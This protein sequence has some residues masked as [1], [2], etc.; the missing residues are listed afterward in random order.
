MRKISTR[1]D[2]IKKQ[3]RNTLII[4]IILIVVI[5]ASVFGIVA[6]SFGESEESKEVFYRGYTFFP[7]GSFWALNQGDFQFIFSNNP[8]ELDNLTFES[9]DLNLLPAY[10]QKVLYL[11]SEDPGS[12]YQIYQNLDRFTVRFQQACL[13][14]DQEKCLEEVPFKNCTDN[15]II[16]RKSNSSKILQQD[17]CV[18][19]EGK[20][21]DLIKLTDVF[22]LKILGI[23]D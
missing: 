17:N 8:E 3:K 18:F 21:E 2:E 23:R 4:S 19:I 11:Y 15:F 16:V 20:S 5:S 22:L 1:K 9:N 14:E 12:S 6:N 13:Q 10:A 7:S